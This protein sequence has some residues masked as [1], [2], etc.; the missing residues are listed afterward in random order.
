[1]VA[2]FF[3]RSSLFCAQNKSKYVHIFKNNLACQFKFLLQNLYA[4]FTYSS[5]KFMEFHKKIYLMNVKN[6]KLFWNVKI[7]WISMFF[8]MKMV[9]LTF[10]FVMVNTLFIKLTVMVWLVVSL[11]PRMFWSTRLPPK[12][13]MNVR[14]QFDILL[15]SLNASHVGAWVYNNNIGLWIHNMQKIIF[16]L[17]YFDGH[18]FTPQKV[19]DIGKVVSIIFYINNFV[20]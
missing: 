13:K 9:Y 5:K 10:L 16:T 15:W 2:T 6:I 17:G 8:I 19:G 18:F 4:I 7:Q 3:Q 20:L 14:G 11:S 1:M 12:W